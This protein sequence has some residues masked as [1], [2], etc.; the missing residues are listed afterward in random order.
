[1][2]LS[3]ALYM[4][5]VLP[6][7]DRSRHGGLFARLAEGSR[8]EKD[9]L[10]VNLELQWQTVKKVLQNAYDDV[11]YYRKVFTEH[12]ITPSAIRHPDD[13]VKVPVLTRDDIRNNY[14]DLCSSRFAC[15]SLL[16]AATGGTTDT[17]VP[18]LRNP[19]CIPARIAVQLQFN[20][21]AGVLP[22][23][24]IFWLWGA[25]SDFPTNPSWRWRIFDRHV[26]RRMYAP[27]S[28]L[29]EEVMADYSRKLDSFRPRGI[30]AYPSPLTT[31]CEYLLATGYKG[32]SPVAAICTAEPVMPEQRKLIEKAL[33]CPVYEHYGTRDFGLVAAE[34]EIHDGLHVNPSAVYIESVPIPGASDGLR[35]ILVTDFL[36]SGFPLIRYKINDCV[37]PKPIQCSCGRGYPLISGIYGRVTDNFYLQDGSVVP[38]ISFTNRIIKVASGIKKLQVIQERPEAFVVKF[39]PDASFSDSSLANLRSKLFEFLG[40]KVELQF[41]QVN[42]IEREASG[43]T[44]LCISRVKPF[45]SPSAISK[46]DA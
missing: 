6:L 39:I 5:A 36:N 24:K 33:G 11:P 16:E 18:I 42:E 10:Q 27:T 14:S 2:N 19:D 9:L 28:L 17:P 46:I 22:G 13:M 15:G 43:K 37:Y 1:M 21:W 29:N 40:T 32:S 20:S 25:R 12:A 8:S 7:V 26:M 44:R 4:K 3:N 23:D 30:M 35:E 41:L 45:G 38:G 31:F 34:C